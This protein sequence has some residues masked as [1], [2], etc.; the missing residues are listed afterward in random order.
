[1]RNVLLV[2]VASFV[3]TA[4]VIENARLKC[5][6]FYPTVVYITHSSPS[7][8]VIYVQVLILA[9]L[10]TKLLQKV[11][12]GTLQQEETDHLYERL[13][14]T[15]TETCLAF[16]VF[17]N[18][19]N[20][21]FIAL[22]TLLLVLKS[23]HYLAEK[24]VELLERSPTIS[25]LCQVRMTF[26]LLILS[27]LDMTLIHVAID[28]VL[29]NGPLFYIVFGFEYGILLVVLFSFT[30]KYMIHCLEI[31]LAVSW[32]EKSVFLLYTQLIFGFINVCLYL[33]FVAAMVSAYVMPL[34]ALRPLY[35]S[36]T[37]FKNT[38]YDVIMSR[39][40]LRNMNTL[41][42]NATQADIEAYDNVCIICREDMHDRAS[43]KLLCNHIFHTSC[44]REWLQR[45]QTCPVCRTSVFRQRTVYRDPNQERGATNPQPTS[46]SGT[47][48][49]AAAVHQLPQGVTL[50]QNFQ[51]NFTQPP[52]PLH[53]EG[54]SLEEL[55][56][57]ESQTREGLLA[58]MEY[59]QHVQTYLQT[60]MVLMQQ[61]LMLPESNIAVNHQAQT[62]NELNDQGTSVSSENNQHLQQSDKEVTS[63]E[64]T[65]E[66]TTS[67]PDKVEAT[68]LT[69]EQ[70]ELV[71]LHRIK[72]FANKEEKP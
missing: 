6:Q 5:K 15:T 59:L 37:S 32:E 18:D 62:V 54:L 8:A 34:F 24:R 43:K 67:T 51:F 65:S 19:F 70:E 23:F 68:G 58:R 38:F 25:S 53:L 33:A 42:P 69:P 40:A 30:L 1:M 72:M 11:F 26:L 21:N 22:L 50:L 17:K 35:Y 9:F 3:L 41:Y 16:T 4:A 10:G 64:S 48:P 2:V 63:T 36:L 39:R 66:N 31:F 55:Q 56:R 44:L 49:P 13:W 71:R 12:F 47:S 57:L 7:M 20:N 28:S 61:C 52:P 45:Q 14:F 60:A 46:T 27:A 29:S